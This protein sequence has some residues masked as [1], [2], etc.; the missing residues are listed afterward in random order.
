MNRQPSV[1]PQRPHQQGQPQQPQ[2]H[3]QVRQPVQIT[4][5]QHAE[6]EEL[7]RLMLTL[8]EFPMKEVVK[9]YI[10]FRDAIQS[11]VKEKAEKTHKILIAELDNF[12][13]SMHEVERAT[14]VYQE[15]KS[16]IERETE[17]KNAKVDD[18]K[19][20]LKRLTEALAREREAVST[21]NKCSALAKKIA[22]TE[23]VSQLK[24]Q[25]E[26]LES[27][28]SELQKDI[29]ELD[30]KLE[31]RKKQF[32]LLMHAAAMLNSEIAQQPRVPPPPLPSSS[33][34][35][36]ENGSTPTASTTTSVPSSPS[37]TATVTVLTAKK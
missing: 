24:A 2:H 30:A 19:A 11:G 25:V 26:K 28:I 16:L 10:E 20:E 13:L 29:G 32:R 5:Q 33:P 12:E 1:N 21:K 17:E 4:P 31:T 3:Q 27:D 36:Q 14:K 18:L 22:C 9:R 35:L 7:A 6:A 8:K 37:K 34:S 15:E 23:S